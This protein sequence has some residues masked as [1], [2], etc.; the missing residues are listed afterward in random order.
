MPSPAR[1]SA[2]PRLSRSA[3]GLAV[4]PSAS[5]CT[6]IGVPCSS[7]PL[8]IST[9]FPAIRWYRLNMSHGRPKPETCP[10]CRGPFAYGQAGAARGWGMSLDPNVSV[11]RQCDCRVPG[12]PDAEDGQE[13]CAEDH[14]A[15]DDQR[16]YRGDHQPQRVLVVQPVVPL[17]TPV[18]EGEDQAD[19][20]PDADQ[21]AD[22]QAALQGKFAEN[23]LNLR[24]LGQEAFRTGVDLRK[25]PEQDGLEA[26]HHHAARGD[27][28]VHVEGYRAHMERARQDRAADGQ[29]RHQQ[30]QAGHAE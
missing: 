20:A 22:D 11:L 5:A 7:V 1:S 16:G 8:T 19:Q 10:M 25:Q 9:R 27:E 26:D 14:L 13:E 12:V 21:G 29:A 17:A 15:A 2:M 28:G 18:E 30:H 6:W 3:S 24:L 23:L 4:T